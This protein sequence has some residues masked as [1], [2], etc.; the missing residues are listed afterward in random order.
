MLGYSNSEVRGKHHSMFVDPAISGA[1]DY[2]AFWAKLARGEPDAGR[3]RRLAK[4]GREVWLQASYNP[5]LDAN[6][7]PFKVV[8]YATDVTE[9][10]QMAQQ[11]ELTVK[12]T[13]ITVTAAAEGD[14]TARIP[15]A[16]KTGE[17][18][19]LCKGVNSMLDTTADLVEARE[20][21]RG[22]KCRRA[23]RR[24]PRATS[25]SRSAPSSRPRA[26]KR[27]RRRWKR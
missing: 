6:G 2:R 27:P 20:G 1:A 21:S 17:L 7:R 26:S 25:I 8:K 12:Q 5:I 3:Y 10:M 14:L 11:L 22:A 15:M 13:Q 24:F 16:G 23:R 19:A 9:Q 4:G 18:E